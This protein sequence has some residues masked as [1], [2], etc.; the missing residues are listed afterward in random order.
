MSFVP[1]PISLT[2]PDPAFES[3]LRD[4]GH[5]YTLDT[6]PSSSSSAPSASASVS[7]SPSKPISASPSCLSSFLSSLRT[8]ATLISINPLAKLEASDLSAPTPSWTRDFIGGPGEYSWPAEASQARMRVQ[9]NVRH[10]ARNYMF[11]SLLFFT[12]CLY[13]MPISLLGLLACLG[14]WEGVRLS[15]KSWEMEKYPVLQQV[16]VKFSLFITAVV[17]YLCNLHF[18]LVYAIGLSYAAMLIHA[19][20]RKLTPLNKPKKVQKRSV[21]LSPK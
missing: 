20:L 15:I 16:M 7:F 21:Q 10:Y 3:W 4:S 6:L 18:S 13:Q 5:L 11:L 17:L 9:E 19:S 2:V 12:C 14:I 8:L 1:N